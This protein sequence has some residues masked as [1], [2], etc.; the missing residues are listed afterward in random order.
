[1]TVRPGSASGSAW[2][3]VTGLW[4]VAADAA[5][6]QGRGAAGPALVHVECEAHSVQLARAQVLNASAMAARILGRKLQGVESSPQSQ[7]KQ[8]IEQRKALST[9][10]ERVLCLTPLDAPV[11]PAGG[12]KRRSAGGIVRAAVGWVPVA[13]LVPGLESGADMQNLPRPLQRQLAQFYRLVVASQASQQGV[14]RDRG[15]ASGGAPELQ[16]LIT[17][18]RSRKPAK[19]IAVVPG[20]FSKPGKRSSGIAGYLP[21]RAGGVGS[22]TEMRAAGV[23]S[24]AEAWHGF[25]TVSAIAK[26]RYT[27]SHGD[28]SALPSGQVAVP[29]PLG[30]DHPVVM[31]P[32]F[33]KL[34]RVSADGS[35]RMHGLRMFVHAFV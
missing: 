35:K 4:Q 18:G 9:A 11:L 27:P 26:Q 32:S 14:M 8:G 12:T 24:Q 6:T 25:S 19:Y 2:P 23:E 10:G 34:P 22:W 33:S 28:A 20:C 30:Q 1:M 17:P 3:L 13:S 15:P 7:S 21:V 16:P 29:M 5:Q 31:Y